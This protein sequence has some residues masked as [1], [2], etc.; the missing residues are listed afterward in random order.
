MKNK[1]NINSTYFPQID[2]LKGFAIVSVILLHTIP[3]S[4]LIKTFSQFYIWQAVPIF[5]ILMGFTSMLSFSHK[6]FNNIKSFYWENY[7]IG[8]FRRIFVPFL[9][10]F[11][12]SL[13]FGIYSGK[14]YIGF[15]YFIGF[16]P[17]TGPG[18]YFVF[19]LFQ[20]IFIAP[21][22][23]LF[24][25]KQP[26][27]ML[28]TFFLIDIS[29]QLITPYISIFNNNPYLYSANI[30]RY[31]SAIALGFYICDDFM[32]NGYVKIMSRK[33]EFMLIGFCISI[34]YLFLARFTWQPF[35]LFPELW[36]FQNVLSF[37]YPLLIIIF[38]LNSNFSN[39]KSNIIYKICLEIGKA[40]YHIFLV[41]I[42]FFGFGLSF[43]ALITKDN[44]LIIGPIA[45]FANLILVLT[46]G[47]GFYSFQR[48]ILQ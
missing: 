8:K 25:Q 26:K 13:L 45:I 27:I 16:L 34:I 15:G 41:Q 48:K 23:Y 36:G 29:F 5:F 10:T 18:N 17:V 7:L 24:Y 38:V 2:L 35:P 6:K 47:L 44:L 40:S 42:L 3:S 37:F 1:S 12:V 21:F 39:Y 19:M 32:K 30:L 31:F 14:Y 11:F 4:L 28:I 43:V 22:I 33:N 46:I 9:I 20:Y